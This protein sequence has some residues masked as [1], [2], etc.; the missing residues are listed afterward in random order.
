MAHVLLLLILLSWACFSF[1]SKRL[2]F[3]EFLHVLQGCL[4]IMVD[5]LNLNWGSLCTMD[6]W[7][8]TRVHFCIVASAPEAN[9]F[10][11][12]FLNHM[13]HL[14]G[15]NH[16]IVVCSSGIMTCS[17]I[18]WLHALG[19]NVMG[20]SLRYG[21]LLLYHCHLCMYPVRVLLE[22]WC[23]PIHNG[24]HPMHMDICS[25]VVTAVWAYANWS[26][27]VGSWLSRQ[28]INSCG[29]M[30]KLLVISVYPL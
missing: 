6:A 23:L 14:P 17:M 5:C 18:K 26:F 11:L 22:Y 4:R 29:P 28:T 2:L 8:P 30:A 3:P 21:C 10:V 16:H 25:I 27:I 9:S 20:S 1:M 19:D 15:S 12:V 7:A 24:C 13:Q